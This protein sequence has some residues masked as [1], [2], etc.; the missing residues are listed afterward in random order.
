MLKLL[1]QISF[2]ALIIFMWFALMLLSLI[3]APIP[4]VGM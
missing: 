4:S 3:A 1:A 2:L